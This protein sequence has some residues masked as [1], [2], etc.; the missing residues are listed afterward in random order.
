MPRKKMTALT[1]PGYER[2]WIDSQYGR[3]HFGDWL[4]L[5]K[6]RIEQAPGRVAEIRESK[7]QQAKWSNGRGKRVE[8]WVN[9]VSEPKKTKVK[10]V[11]QVN[12]EV[13]AKAAEV[14]K[15]MHKPIDSLRTYN[16]KKRR[17]RAAGVIWGT[18]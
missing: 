15:A 12:K 17:D 1:T 6:E 11:A 3:V 5:E 13:N 16:D 2:E 14:K 8:L 7:R 10:S 4:E 18:P 9:D